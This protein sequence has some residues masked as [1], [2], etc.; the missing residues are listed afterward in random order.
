MLSQL[1]HVREG[2]RTR[3]VRS[4]WS[5][6]SLSNLS[7]GWEVIRQ[8]T[9]HLKWHRVTQRSAK[10]SILNVFVFSR[11]SSR[12]F[13]GLKNNWIRNRQGPTVDPSKKADWPSCCELN[14]YFGEKH[15]G[16]IKWSAGQG[17]ELN[18]LGDLSEKTEVKK[19][20]KKLQREEEE[21]HT[22]HIFTFCL[23]T[24]NTVLFSPADS[25]ERPVIMCSWWS[26]WNALVH[27][28]STLINLHRKSHLPLS[29]FWL[30]S[31][32]F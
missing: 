10:R 17:R 1:S 30:P 6:W 8:N 22:Q 3:V 9:V 32:Y 7:E 23:S 27:F 29:R 18:W 4:V 24:P 14:I 31:L 25:G 20:N 21:Y 15:S 26:L 16:K 13:W 19:R 28:S 2:G 12:I 5:C 11:N